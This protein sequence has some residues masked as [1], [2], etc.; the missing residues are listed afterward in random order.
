MKKTILSFLCLSSTLFLFSQ[1][2]NNVIL[3]LNIGQ[4]NV[5]GRAQPDA[6]NEI[7]PAAGAY[8]Y[9]QSTNTL[10][11]LVDGIGEGI[12]HATD[13]SMNPMLGKRLKELTGHDVIIVPA[14]CGNTFINAWLKE[15]NGLYTNA[16]SMWQAA[17]SYCNAN[18]ITIAA[19]YAHWLQGEND[20][21]GTE[22]DGYYV[23]LNQLT[24]DL[25][26]D[27][28]VEKVF[29]T[30]IGYDPNYTPASNSE[31][32]MKAQ[33]ILNYNNP[34]FIMA[35]YAPP[36]FTVANGKMSYD[37][38]HHALPG[39]NQV[40]EDVVTAIQHYRA[41]GTKIQ[42]AENV[43]SLQSVTNGYI[44]LTQDWGFEF[45]GN[46]TEVHNNVTMGITARSWVAPAFS[47]TADGGIT[48]AQHTGLATSRPF[49]SAT[50]TLE[51]RLKMNSAAGWSAVAGNGSG[52]NFNKL[53]ISHNNSTSETTVQFGTATNLYAWNLGTAVNMSTYHTLKLTQAGGVLRL[54][55]DGVQAGA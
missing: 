15:T 21:G 12:S 2:P 38:T 25:I 44:N 41:T 49:S 40:A 34:N 9:K 11:T 1:A 7:A 6:A 46:T 10:E 39:L 48:L 23:M 3:V 26:S 8:W 33:K 20:A 24:N 14:G 47:Y 43:A 51:V 52:G 29:A 55:V 45:A 54:Y 5:V 18:N 28:G 27:V 30:R 36:T 37:L 16:K 13:R 50:F 19:K 31:K 32:I 42:L 17:V 35:S 22:T 53:V 4:S